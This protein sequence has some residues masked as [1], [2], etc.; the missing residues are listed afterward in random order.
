MV[1]YYGFLLQTFNMHKIM[2]LIV[3]ELIAEVFV[4]L[5]CSAVD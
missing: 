3:T 1:M 4:H 2:F 5:L